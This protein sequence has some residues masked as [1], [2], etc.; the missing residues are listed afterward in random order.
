MNWQNLREIEPRSSLMS[1]LK[2]QST[3]KMLTN[4]NITSKQCFYTA[5]FTQCHN[6]LNSEIYAN[7]VDVITHD[8]LQFW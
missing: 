6:Y 4:A 1:N 8:M 3:H 5:L 7:Q 2:A